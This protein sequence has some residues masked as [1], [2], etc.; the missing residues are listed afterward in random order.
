MPSLTILDIIDNTVLKKDTDG[1]EKFDSSGGGAFKPY[2]SNECVP[3][4]SILRKTDHN[5]NYCSEPVKNSQ[6]KS[7]TH[8]QP[9]KEETAPLNRENQSARQNP[10][11][12]NISSENALNLRHNPIGQIL[13]G[14]EKGV[15]RVYNPIGQNLD[16]LTR[17]PPTS[18]SQ[19]S[20][21]GVG[22]NSLEGFNAVREALLRTSSVIKDIDHMLEKRTW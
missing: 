7:K 11:G 14:S 17:F 12:Q 18:R 6:L 20:A 5:S 3:G 15:N 4:P 22:V 16:V 1:C 21:V 9:V 13:T 19:L 2:N 10:I 8:F